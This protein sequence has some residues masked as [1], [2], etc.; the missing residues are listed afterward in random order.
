VVVVVVLHR[1]IVE[2]VAVA[3]DIQIIVGVWAILL[4]QSHRKGTMEA[5]LLPMAAVVAG[6]EPQEVMVKVIRRLVVAEAVQ[7]LTL[8]VQV[9][10][11]RA[12]VVVQQLV[13]HRVEEELEAAAMGLPLMV[14]LALVVVRTQAVVVAPLR[15]IIII[16]V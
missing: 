15:R 3:E 2:E 8:R 1:A 14:E 12:A 13:L 10:L 7:H 16:V 6:Q 5:M 4:L 11:V 9:L